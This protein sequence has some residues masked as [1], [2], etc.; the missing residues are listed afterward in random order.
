M[1]RFS[2]S[3]QV[4]VSLEALD[5]RCGLNG[6]LSRIQKMF[7]HLPQEH[8]LF[9]F[10]DRRCKKVKAVF[11]DKNG[12]M[13]LYKRLETGIFQFP[14]I[15]AGTISLNRLQ[16]E[17]LLSGMNFIVPMANKPNEYSVFS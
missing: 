6:L 7:G 13:L 10:C 5:F 14:K 16:L 11:W 17:C 8:Y 4:Y 12:F 1:I 2:A 9:L 15:R 3:I